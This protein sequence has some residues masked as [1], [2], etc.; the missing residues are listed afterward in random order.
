MAATEA[1]KK[2]DLA[3]PNESVKSTIGMVT[4]CSFTTTYLSAILAKWSKGEYSSEDYK[5]GNCTIT[6]STGKVYPMM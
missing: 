5:P 4:K 1:E 3:K 6:D 2:E